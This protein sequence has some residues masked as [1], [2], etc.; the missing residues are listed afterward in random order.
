MAALRSLQ[1]LLDEAFRVPGTNLRFGWDPL[2]GV[3]PWLGDLLTAVFSCAI[4]VQAHRMRVPRVVQ[5]RMLA[6]LGIDLIVG[7]IPLLGDVA[8]MFWKSN[9]KNFA[10]LE[11]HAAAPVAATTGDWLFAIGI[12]AAVI[13]MALIPL[14]VLYWLLNVVTAHL[15]ALAR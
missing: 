10:L 12:V 15:P 3:V 7:A 2:L 6:N 9:T 5:F 8:D 1:R 11:R 13:G 4:I 14:F